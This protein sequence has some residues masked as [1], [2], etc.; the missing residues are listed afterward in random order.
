MVAVESLIASVGGN[1]A[2]SVVIEAL[3]GTERRACRSGSARML[4]GERTWD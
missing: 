2:D 1:Q 4:A 3:V